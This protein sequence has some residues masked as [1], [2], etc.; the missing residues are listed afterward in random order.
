MAWGRVA[1]LLA[2]EQA[3]PHLADVATTLGYTYKASHQ[4]KGKP[5]SEQ[6]DSAILNT[7]LTTEASSASQQAV[8][9]QIQS[10]TE[11]NETQKEAPDYLYDPDKCMDFNKPQPGTFYFDLPTPLVTLANIIPLLF[12]TLGEEKISKRVNQRKLIRQVSQ[13]KSLKTIPTYLQK[14]WPG[15]L[16]IIVDKHKMLFPYWHDF[17]VIAEQLQ[18][19]LGKDQVNILPFIDKRTRKACHHELLEKQGSI[20]HSA[21][22]ILSDLLDHGSNARYW[23]W[24]DLLILLKKKSCKVLTLSPAVT[25]PD[26]VELRKLAYPHSLSLQGSLSRYPKQKG[27][28][29]DVTESMLE[30]ALTI[31]SPLILVDRGLLRKLRQ[32]FRWGNAATEGRLWNHARIVPDY[33]GIRLKAAYREAY[34][35]KFVQLPKE[36]QAQLWQI[37]EA[38]HQAAYQG[39]KRLERMSQAGLSG[40][41]QAE[42]LDYYQ[43]L[44]ASFQQ[45]KIPDIQSALRQQLRTL[46]RIIPAMAWQKDNAERKLLLDV[47]AIAYQ[48]EIRA[49]KWPENLPAGLDINEVQWI[50][51]AENIE[52]VETYYLAQQ[53]FN[54]EATVST[55]IPIAGNILQFT[56]FPSQ[57]ASLEDGSSSKQRI[58]K[59]TSTFT[60]QNQKKL[61][62]KN[63]QKDWQLGSIKRPPFA[64]NIGQ[65]T[66]G[67]FIETRLNDPIS[68]V[69]W[70]PEHINAQGGTLRGS[71][72]PETV[73]PAG[74]KRDQYGVYQD[75]SIQ[76]ITQRFRWIEPG[77]FMMGSPQ[78]EKERYDDEDLHQ[79]TLTQGF[80]L[81]DTT[82]VQALW[83]A[84][85][86][87]N[88]AR[89]TGDN[90]PVEQV[91]WDDSQTFIEKLQRETGLALLRLPTEAEWEYAC[92]AGTQTPF[93]FGENITPE[94]VN[95]D[96][97]RPYTDG[98]KG[99]ERAET[100]EVKSLPINHWG[101][102]EMHG[103][104][105]EWCQ[106]TWQENL[107]KD[108]VVDPL[109]QQQGVDRV[110]RGGS[111]RSNGRFVRSAIRRPFSPDNRHG[112]IGFR[113]ALGHASQV[114]GG[115]ADRT[116]AKAEPQPSGL[117]DRLRNAAGKIK[118]YL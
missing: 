114:A 91:S 84:V 58:L 30:E 59:S 102:Y 63:K 64:M 103:N 6:D 34:Q 79:V 95:Y 80:W 115:Q 4:G 29:L 18:Q 53:A 94:Q 73:L 22:L 113:L 27:F 52:Q 8:F 11:K 118:D 98:E 104:V 25:S 44:L 51:D 82:V 39:L 41:T 38:H 72:F 106:D 78:D 5:A 89:F 48:E 13:G 101:L 3:K 47:Y 62:I 7:G 19:L 107:G 67:L 93:F 10:I 26:D 40:Q 21:V 69:Y 20:N 14:Y 2:A 28:R 42:T 111:W 43:S 55:E 86:G 54:A 35:Q 117:F 37:V 50:R 16:T 12:N 57:P 71:W 83:Q 99:Q 65:N 33:L 32:A 97:S 31:I 100:V 36:Q 76:S 61:T 75:I 15:R 46:I 1:L 24:H 68:R 60:I 45:T 108:S 17:E 96:G 109:I 112:F 23:D 49:G 77:Q 116:V 66:Q 56:S 87:K 90:R 92:R 110:V 70:L 85:M 9:W 74:I 105:W 81:A 88:P